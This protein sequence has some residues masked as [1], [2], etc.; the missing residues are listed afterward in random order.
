ML[1]IERGSEV[2]PVAFFSKQLHGAQRCYSAQELQG[3]AVYEAIRHF[4]FHLYGRRF[5]VITD[6]KGLV[7]LRTGRQ[8]N[9]RIYGWSL[10]LAEF[11]FEMRY[12]KGEL[13]VVADDLS[14]CHSEDSGDTTRILEEEGDVGQPT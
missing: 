4:A 9:R 1:S 5:V 8:E 13:N 2:L 6:H 14:R 3:L 12:R 7:S 10:K 11:D